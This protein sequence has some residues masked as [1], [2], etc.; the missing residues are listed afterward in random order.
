MSRSRRQV[1]RVVWLA[2]LAC[3]LPAVR[4]AHALPPFLE[5]YLEAYVL[6]RAYPDSVIADS[7]RRAAYVHLSQLRDLL[8]SVHRPPVFSDTAFRAPR[9]QRVPCVWRSIGPTNVNGRVTG[10]AFDPDDPRRVFASTVGGVWR[11]KN[12]GRVWYRVTDNLAQPVGVGAVDVLPPARWGCVA[13]AGGGSAEVFAGS[14]DPNYAASLYPTARDSSLGQGIWRS[15]AGGNPGTWTRVTPPSLDGQTIF[16][17]RI[18]PS[19]QDVYAATSRGI[20]K[21][22]HSGTLMTWSRV[23]GVNADGTIQVFDA[24]CS[25]LVVDFDHVDA[26]G[27]HAPLL[28]AGV[29]RN[30]SGSRGVWKYVEGRWR[31]RISGMTPLQ[32]AAGTAM[33]IGAVALA[34]APQNHSL[35][36]ARVSRSDDGYLLGVFRTTTAA[37]A[38]GGS[39]AWEPLVDSGSAVTTDDS[40][41]GTSDG[42]C[43]FNNVLEVDPAD[44]HLL[45][46]GG[47]FLYVS[48]DA[49]QSPPSLRN[50]SASPGPG[51]GEVHDDVHAI[52]FDPRGGHSVL[53]GSDGGIDRSTDLTQQV[54]DPLTG[55]LKPGWHWEHL[56]HGMTTTEFFALASQDRAEA[57]AAAGGQDNGTSITFGNRTWYPLQTCDAYG[58]ALDAWNALTVYQ[59]CNGD[60]RLL[61]N[62]V[63]GASGALSRAE[64]LSL[65]NDAELGPPFAADRTAPLQ[66]LAAGRYTATPQRAGVFRT[67]GASPDPIVWEEVSGRLASGMRVVSLAAAP[68]FS[69]YLAGLRNLSGTNIRI[70]SFRFGAWGTVAANLPQDKSPNAVAFAA[71]DSN[72]AYAA[73]GGSTGG[74]LAISQNGGGAWQVA[75]N[76]NLTVLPALTA[77][78]VSPFQPEVVFVGTVVGV[79]RGE[80]TWGTPGTTPPEVH[81]F[82]FDDGMPDAVDVTGLWANRVAGTLTASTMGYGAFERPIGPEAAPCFETM[83]VVRDNVFDRGGDPSPSGLPDPEHPVETGVNGF[84]AA[85]AGS[86]VY[87]WSSTDIRLENP[88]LPPAL[89]G[90]RVPPPGVA[91]ML[92]PVPIEADAVEVETC[93]IQHADCPAGSMIDSPPMPGRR[94]RVHVQVANHGLR[95]AQNVRVM[96]LWANSGVGLGPLPG[97]FWSSRF[98]PGSSSCP[99]YT[100]LG[101]WHAVDT[102][103]PCRRIKI[104]N[105]DQ[106]ATV[107]FEWRVP[108]GVIKDHYCMLAIAD[109]RSDPI[110]RWIRDSNELSIGVLVPR[111]RHIAQRNLHVIDAARALTPFAGD[112]RLFFGNPFPAGGNFDLVVTRS[113]LPPGVSLE[114]GVQGGRQPTGVV[115]GAVSLA[116][117][118][119][120]SGRGPMWQVTANEAVFPGLRI[121]PGRSVPVEVRYRSSSGLPPDIQAE[122]GVLARQDTTVVGGCTYLLRT[123]EEP[124]RTPPEPTGRRPRSVRP[125]R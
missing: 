108:A 59:S 73:F 116:P 9:P 107:T 42:Y 122:F 84:W 83:L 105:P 39:S 49:G 104:L 17:I 50:H 62:P 96:A 29:Y 7:T 5:S 82:P 124:G 119:S 61:T 43:W 22:V 78:A 118:D 76:R 93:P 30:G 90:N 72:L 103:E 12:S 24:G 52:A 48:Y 60:F 85:D 98:P 77:L 125:K 41:S 74:A 31:L 10:I 15:A 16:R 46:I 63:V 95:P 71:A 33:P 120:G 64:N 19:T 112:V 67:M 111:S 80:I 53:I 47:R 123:R 1:L 11:S 23:D 2:L 88:G 89:A 65:P 36:F 26:L 58:V 8:L 35:L 101:D 86:P 100:N 115:S 68:G 4:P 69:R 45:V 109:C 3:E 20:W 117:A 79:L 27:H 54:A 38:A 114:V 14:G 25:D 66:A 113:G 70:G 75:V 110:E 51:F 97:D 94:M 40:G 55:A 44:S 99:P 13:A 106:P 34:M 87:W 121:E 28:Y 32:P 102:V 92:A 37:E 91:A 57:A 18:D 21:G 6:P 56:S 81:W